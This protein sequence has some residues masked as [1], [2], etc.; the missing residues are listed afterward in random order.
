MSFFSEKIIQV[1]EKLS[2]HNLSSK[3]ETKIKNQFFEETGVDLDDEL[4]DG[5]PFCRK[6]ICDKSKCDFNH[7]NRDVY[8]RYRYNCTN[9]ECIKKHYDPRRNMT[10]C[11][12]RYKCTNNQCP[13]IHRCK[14]GNKCNNP[15]CNS[16]HD[17]ERYNNFCYQD[18]TCTIKKCKLLHS[19]PIKQCNDPLCKNAH[20]NRSNV[21]CIF[22]KKCTVDKCNMSHICDKMDDCNKPSCHLEHNE[23]RKNIFCS[24]DSICRGKK[25]GECELKHSV[26][27]KQHKVKQN[28]E[29]KGKRNTN[30]YSCLI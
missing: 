16:F 23:S 6:I 25:N 24:L 5:R 28:V 20:K 8:C 17:P 13:L 19:C 3:E 29:K 10:A 14:H 18:R 9:T 7:L 11:F 1:E 30:I 12:L 4:F 26:Y 22:G 15:T 2:Q 27:I 21:K